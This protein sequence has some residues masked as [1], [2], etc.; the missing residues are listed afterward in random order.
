MTQPPIPQE[1]VEEASARLTA[2]RT[3]L[4]H[5][6]QEIGATEHGELRS[7]VE[8]GDGGFADAAAATAERTEAL[9]L[10]ETLAQQVAAIDEALDLIAEGRYGYCVRC[11]SAMSPARIE[12]RPESVLCVECKN[13]Q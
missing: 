11:G 6:L 1:I 13:R 2:E 5:Q 3:R 9:G 12:A 10:A 7:D 8:F 4:V